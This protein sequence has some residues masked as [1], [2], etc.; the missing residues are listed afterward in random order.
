M[1][2][3]LAFQRWGRGKRQKTDKKKKKEIV[4]FNELSEEMERLELLDPVSALLHGFR[5]AGIM[6]S[7][8]M[9]PACYLCN[10]KKTCE[11]KE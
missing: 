7:S 9:V 2:S 8:P 4:S 1:I 11:Q 10:D 6:A 3:L 5:K